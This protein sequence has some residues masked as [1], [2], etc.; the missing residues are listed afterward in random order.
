[1]T[2]SLEMDRP[3]FLQSQ[4]PRWGQKHPLSNHR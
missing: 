4:S 1:M 2:Y 3:P